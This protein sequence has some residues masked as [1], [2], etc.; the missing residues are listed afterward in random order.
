[1]LANADLVL[2]VAETAVRERETFGFYFAAHPVEGYRAVASANGARSYASLIE[3][4]VAGGGRQAAVMAALVEG[5]SKGRTR[6]GGEFIRADFS[7]SSGQFSAACFEESLVDSF[8]RWAAD[9]TCVLLNVELDSPSPDEPPRVT[10]RGA[11]P[12]A[13]VRN[14]ARMLLTLDVHTAEAL[15]EL[16]LALIEGEAGR[17]EVLAR[18][19]IGEGTDPLVRLGR[20]F[21]LDG[22]LAERLAH[23]DG[24]ANVAL[25]TR[26]TQAQLRLVA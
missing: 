6:R 20:D 9:G 8:Q 4:G 21:D 14:D 10:V 1:V 22:E 17:G 26:R 15:Q 19:R 18:L 3:S 24:L 5:V 16:R 12:L 13:E 2:S 25:T 7:D 11:R 23:I